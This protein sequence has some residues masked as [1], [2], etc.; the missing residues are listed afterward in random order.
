M[1]AGRSV[2]GVLR[3]GSHGFKLTFFLLVLSTPVAAV[4]HDARILEN[5]FV[6]GLSWDSAHSEENWIQIFHTDMSTNDGCPATVRHWT[7]TSGSP[8]P[9]PN[10]TFADGG[11]PTVTFHKPGV[12]N[13]T[14]HGEATCGDSWDATGTFYVIGGPFTVSLEIAAPWLHDDPRYDTTPWYLTYFDYDPPSNGA[15]KR[16]GLQPT[17]KGKAVVKYAQP[18]GTTF[19]WSVTG[20]AKEIGPFPVG[21]TPKTVTRIRATA[22]SGSAGDITI[23]LTYRLTT[24]AGSYGYMDD[25]TWMWKD[26]PGTENPDYVRFASHRPQQ[27]DG[28]QASDPVAQFT[29]PP[30]E[31]SCSRDYHY[32]VRDQLQ[33]H[34]PGVDVQE[35]FPA[36]AP[37]IVWNGITH[38]FWYTSTSE[39]DDGNAGW[40]GPD[41]IICWADFE[42]SYYD[43]ET[44][45]I[46]G[47]PHE[48]W[49][50]TTSCTTGSGG[51][52]LAPDHHLQ[53][54][55]DY[56]SN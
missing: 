50:G 36:G 49:A 10:V 21:G 52:H 42:Y 54:W 25:S 22:G 20:S 26:P 14:F 34:T 55:T 56:V 32:R 51:V 28:E 17:V 12:L 30:P 40:F 41:I 19:D 53:G 31:W 48:Y 8:S 6:G 39:Y 24:P 37:L 15:E 1:R 23:C 11:T 4:H 44:P 2:L 29:F 45:L 16:N 35:R 38:F 13:I 7:F 43:Y 3:R 47:N 46:D 27:I 5:N 9:E 18:A 33:K